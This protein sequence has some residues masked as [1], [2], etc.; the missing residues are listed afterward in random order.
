MAVFIVCL[1]LF[2]M[3]FPLIIKI[4]NVLVVNLSLLTADIFTLVFGVFLFQFKVSF[5]HFIDI[6]T[7][8]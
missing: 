2:Y 7:K 6:I 4:S 8:H 3:T 1:C 5:V